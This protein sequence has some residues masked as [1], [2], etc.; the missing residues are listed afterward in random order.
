MYDIL[1][2]SQQASQLCE[3]AISL[4]AGQFVDGHP[5]L[6]TLLTNEAILRINA[7]NY[8]GV[9]RLCT[10]AL[11]LLQDAGAMNTEIELNVLCAFTTF[12]IAQQRFSE[13]EAIARQAQALAEQ[14]YPAND[15]RLATPLNNIATI[16]L[17]HRQTKAAEKLFRRIVALP[18][19][20]SDISASA[21]NLAVLCAGTGNF[22]QALSFSTR[23]L[24]M[25][26]TLYGDVHA[27]VGV[28]LSNLGWL[29]LQIGNNE[30][31]ERFLKEALLVKERVLGASDPSL[32]V[33]RMNLANLYLATGRYNSVI[34]LCERALGVFKKAYRQDH[35]Y[36]IATLQTYASALWQT[37]HDGMAVHVEDRLAAIR[38]F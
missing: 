25:D 38:G 1:G 6:P 36:N 7:G 32:A 29:Y 22:Q 12:Y 10:E 33:T 23:A 26:R 14:I 24:S 21:S 13:A 4:H 35:V 2:E 9:E 17:L 28:D 34:P 15:A 27:R 16:Y 8:A 20:N 31:A 37:H 30:Y 11:R 5:L 18:A 19:I 3:R